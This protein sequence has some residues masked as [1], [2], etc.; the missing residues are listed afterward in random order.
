MLSS[1]CLIQ[2]M[3]HRIFSRSIELLC[4]EQS[5]KIIFNALEGNYALCLLG[6]RFRLSWLYF[7][8]HVFLVSI[9]VIVIFSWYFV[10]VLF[11][12]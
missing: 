2:M 6:E 5:T 1:Q 12:S 10:Y 7:Q 9:S 11:S 3:T 8:E 4:H